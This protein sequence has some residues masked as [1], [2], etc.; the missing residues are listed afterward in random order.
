M[1]RTKVNPSELKF[2]LLSVKESN[3]PFL[4]KYNNGSGKM[5]GL[6][7]SPDILKIVP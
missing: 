6:L 3:L 5:E 2:S 1:F 4:I 7:T